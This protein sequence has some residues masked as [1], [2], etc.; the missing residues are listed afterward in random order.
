[1]TTFNGKRLV[2]FCFIGVM[3][4]LLTSC[5]S[6]PHKINFDETLPLEETAEVLF[7]QGIHVH[8]LNGIAVDKT[9]YGK[10]FSSSESA[11]VR[12]PAGETVVEYELYYVQSNGQYS[13]TTFRAKDQEITY[14]FEA[15]KKYNLYFGSR[16]GFLGIGAKHGIFLSE[17]RKVL[18]FW[19]MT[20]R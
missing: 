12:L 14:T 16:G 6:I 5:F 18:Q 15:G 11:R 1:M 20:F 10:S 13:T 4:L 8:A 7:N 19:E 9:W 3:V 17:K 2:S